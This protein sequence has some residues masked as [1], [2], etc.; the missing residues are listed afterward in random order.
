[1]EALKCFVIM[2][3]ADEFNDVYA[4]IRRAAENA[5]SGEQLACRRLDEIKTPGKISVDLTTELENSAMAIADLT[6]LNANVMWETGY[7]MALKKPLLL[8]TQ[9][10]SSLPFDLRDYR[11][12][13]YNRGDLS[14]SLEDKLREAVRDTLGSGTVPRS[15]LERFVVRSGSGT[16]AVT[17]SMDADR[18]RCER[19]VEALLGP[20]VGKGHRW[21]C[22]SYGVADEVALQYLVTHRENITIYAH[23]AYDI[24]DGVRRLVEKEEVPFVDSRRE[25]I[26]KV[27]PPPTSERDALF[28]TKAD[29]VILFWNGYSEGVR[30]LVGWL[31]ESGRDH[32]VGF[33]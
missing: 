29:L 16:I 13:Q 8:L 17:G 3:F 19:R 23:H 1:M 4:T 32:L 2:P 6:G 26:P 18:G 10:I 21:L 11:V 14:K 22:G 20:H 12:I 7:A 31:K 28:V 25:Q 9:N 30:E 15:A 33:I 5:V 24:S 27:S